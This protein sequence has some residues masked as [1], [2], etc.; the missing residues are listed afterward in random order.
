MHVAIFLLYVES[1][2]I[3]KFVCVN[4]HSCNYTK[5]TCSV[6][7]VYVVWD[8]VEPSFILLHK[9]G[10]LDSFT[11]IVYIAASLYTFMHVSP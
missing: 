3:T 5:I 9:Q 1:A 11:L 4:L 8:G 7:I 2:L 6:E 10:I